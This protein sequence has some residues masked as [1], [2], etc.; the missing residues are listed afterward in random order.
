M[1]DR[2]E[3]LREHTRTGAEILMELADW[4]VGEIERLRSEIKTFQNIKVIK[5]DDIDES[6]GKF[7]EGY[8]HSG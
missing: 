6:F 2:L 7:P 8:N 1:S 4:A 3:E 5:D